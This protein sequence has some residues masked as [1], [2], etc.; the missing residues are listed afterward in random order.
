[1]GTRGTRNMKA[2]RRLICNYTKPEHEAMLVKMGI[3]AY[4]DRTPLDRE[5]H[6]EEI[7]QKYGR[8]TPRE[9][10]EAYK[11]EVEQRAKI[12]PRL[13]CKG[14]KVVNPWSHGFKGV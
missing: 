14:E 6:D 2:N 11:E 3:I 5:L 7:C 1:M 10:R 9:R 12:V 4:Y 8:M 13:I